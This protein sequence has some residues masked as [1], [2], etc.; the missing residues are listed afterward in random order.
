VAINRIMASP[1]NLVVM[2]IPNAALSETD[3]ALVSALF[4]HAHPTV[5]VGNDNTPGMTAARQMTEQMFPTVPQ[6][7]DV[8]DVVD[9]FMARRIVCT[10]RVRTMLQ[11]TL[12][13]HVPINFGQEVAM[14][15]LI[16]IVPFGLLMYNKTLYIP[17][18]IQKLIRTSRT[19]ISNAAVGVNGVQADIVHDIGV[20]PTEVLGLMADAAIAVDIASEVI[21][22][23]VVDATSQVLGAVTLGAGAVFSGLVSAGLVTRTRRLVV[24]TVSMSLATFHMI[25]MTLPHMRA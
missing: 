16:S 15:T 8:R 17:R 1:Y 13:K 19:V 23:G 10:T 4:V 5:F 6:V 14:R 7:Q 11:T 2:F 20:F 24:H 9:A 3:R 25:Y 12:V 18:L 22:D 21:L